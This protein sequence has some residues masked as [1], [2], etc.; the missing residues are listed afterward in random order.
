MN[1][2]SKATATDQMSLQVGKQFEDAIYVKVNM[3]VQLFDEYGN[4]KQEEFVHNT[5]TTAGKT[6][7]AAQC[8][9]APGVGKMLAHAIGTG[10]PTGTALQTEVGRVAVSSNT[11]ATN[12][13]TTVAT[14]GA[15][16]GTG[17]ITEAGTFDNVTAST[18][19]MWMS[20]SFAV[21]N[22][23][24][25]DSLVITWTLTIN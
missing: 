18:G 8:A 25:A 3:R 13:D 12:V 15:G 23:L 24:A 7:I 22:K 20:A 14:F 11:S 9:S 1:P 5:V 19:N 4:L 17:A 10:T 21:V 2:D 16:V 6:G